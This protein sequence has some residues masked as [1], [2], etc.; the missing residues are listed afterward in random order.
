MS[1][2]RLSA[3][4]LTSLAKPLLESTRARLRELSGEDK[5]LLWALRRKLVKELG[6][7]ERGKPIHRV[8][9]KKRKLA[10]Q[11]GLCLLCCQVLPAKGSILD[12]YEAMKGYTPENTRLLCVPCDTRVQAERGYA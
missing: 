11:Q 4:E 6:Y 9:L 10:E 5:A 7:D 8:A 1:N 3:D 12:R 2:R